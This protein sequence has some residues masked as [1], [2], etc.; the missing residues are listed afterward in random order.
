MKKNKSVILI[1]LCIPLLLS[2]GCGVNY[3]G[4]YSGN[5]TM[6]VTGM[7]PISSQVSVVI[8]QQGSSNT[9]SGT[10]SGSG[11]SGTFQ[12][13]PS[14]NVISGVTLT[15][16][17]MNMM[18]PGMM[19]PG[20][21]QPGVVQPGVIQPGVTSPLAGSPMNCG[22]MTWT[23]TLNVNNNDLSGTLT[24]NQQMQQASVYGMNPMCSGSLTITAR[25]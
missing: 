16:T 10:M 18:Q 3:S 15:T 1:G 21:V 25:K 2:T 23:G 9:V 5:Q 8:N 20:V 13:T 7:S 14:G 17:G 24:S 19:Q 4:T 12:G 22:T 11:G 6:T